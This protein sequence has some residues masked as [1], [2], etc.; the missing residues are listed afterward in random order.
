VPLKEFAPQGQKPEVKPGDLVELFVERYEDRTAPSCCR[1]RRR[2]A[3]R[4]GPTWR[5]RS[6]R[7]QRV[8]GVIF[9]RVKGGFTVDLGGAVAFLPGSRWTSAP[10]ATSAR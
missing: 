3:R 4:P 8:N 6:R 10:C 1:A 9:G 7:N 5:R 2:G